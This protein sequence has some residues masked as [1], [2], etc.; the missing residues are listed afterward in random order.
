MVASAYGVIYT[1]LTNHKFHKQ[2]HDVL[3]IFL[4]ATLL[5]SLLK[6]VQVC[7][8]WFV[9][10]CLFFHNVYSLLQGLSVGG[11]M[12]GSM[13]FLCEFSPKEER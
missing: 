12:V 4:S 13:L 5:L 10:L 6:L 3:N 1:F 7:F 9:F 8:F 2:N 11:E